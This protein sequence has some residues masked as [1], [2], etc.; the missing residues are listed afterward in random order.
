MLGRRTHSW[1]MPPR[2]L[3]YRKVNGPSGPRSTHRSSPSSTPKTDSGAS[4]PTRCRSGCRQAQAGR[5]GAGR[6]D[7]FHPHC[8]RCGSRRSSGGRRRRG[9][10]ARHVGD[11]QSA[12]VDSS[13]ALDAAPLVKP[14]MPVAID[15]QA[16]GI[17]AKGVV[18]RWRAHPGTRGVDGYHV[19]FEV[20]VAET[21]AKLEGVSVRLTI[22]T[23]STKARRPR[24]PDQCALARR[25]RHV[26]SPGAE[27]QGR[28]RI[29]RRRAGPVRRRLRRSDAG[30]WSA[31]AGPAVVVGYK[32]PEQ[33]S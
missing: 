13:L 23:E 16:L 12:G 27:Q 21:Q 24:R 9:S 6:R 3:A 33:G 28:A 26:A 4:Q 32:K 25:R 29:R 1:P 14:G 30:E 22:P 19:Y 18:E 5:T 2:P 20:R 7:R 31:G 17:K 8:S 10:R 15:E 11:R